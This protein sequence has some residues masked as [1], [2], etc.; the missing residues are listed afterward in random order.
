MAGRV[1]GQLSESARALRSAAANPDL[2]RLELAL[3]ALVLGQWAYTVVVAVYAYHQGGAA[4]VGLV[5][6]IRMLPAAFAAPITA[7]LADRYRRQRVLLVAGTCEGL[8]VGVTAAAVAVTAPSVLVY[9]ITAVVQLA[10]TAAVPARAA[11]IPSLARS[12]EELTAANVAATTIDSVG[13]FAGPAVAGVLVGFADVDIVLAVVAG[14][15]ASAVVL[16]S[17]IRPD[18]RRDAPVGLGGLGHELLAGARAIVAQ[19]DLAVLTGLYGAQTFVAGALNVLVVVTA[20]ELLAIGD[21]GVGYLNAVIGVGGLVGAGAMFA[22][23]GVRRLAP[24]FALGMLLWGLPMLLLAAWPNEVFAFAVLGLLGIGNTL[25]DVAGVTLLQRSVPN[26]VLARVFGVLESLTWGTIALGSIAASGLVV[27]LGGRWALALTG[28]LLPVLTALAW[29]R[30]RALDARAPD[31]QPLGLLLGVPFLSPLPPP[32]VEAL[33][34]RLQE[35]RFAAG[36]VVFER[37][38]PGDAFYI[39]GSGEV[40]VE[41]D[42]PTPVVLRRGD[43]FGEIALLARVPRTATARARTG[44]EAYVLPGDV[45]VA[46]VS[47]HAESAESAGLVIATRLGSA[48]PRGAA[49]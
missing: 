44:V 33:A 47:G 11:L 9:V 46:A 16:L 49:A 41:A 2:R 14:V 3:I 48:G 7:L 13:A 34:A 15:F 32:V 35:V 30:L 19:V 10:T 38:D 22:L 18:A 26:D 20:L 12:P 37:G 4:A 39:V 45:F 36:E 17:R 28:A 8:G 27:A 43:F 42:A 31:E 23:V 24:Y 6:L 29:R 1:R 21:A 40:E 5:G 25:V